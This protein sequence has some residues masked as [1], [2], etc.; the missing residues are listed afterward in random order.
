M[1]GRHWWGPS[2]GVFALFVCSIIDDDAFGSE[3]VIRFVFDAPAATNK[4]QILKKFFQRFAVLAACQ[5]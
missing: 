3:V 1:I 4:T 2:L 5:C